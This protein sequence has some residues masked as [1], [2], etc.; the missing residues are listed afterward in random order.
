MQPEHAGAQQLGAAGL[1]VGAAVAV[2]R[3]TTPNASVSA[4]VIQIFVQTAPPRWPERRQ[5]GERLDGG[6]VATAAKSSRAACVVKI[7]RS[8]P[9]RRRTGR[10]VTSHQTTSRIRLRRKTS[11]TIAPSA[12]EGV[13]RAQPPDRQPGTR[14]DAVCWSVIDSDPFSAASSGS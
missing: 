8:T 9:R 1:L 10:R 14:L 7:T 13:R 12:G 4:H 3:N 5:S 6:N 11:R 2:T